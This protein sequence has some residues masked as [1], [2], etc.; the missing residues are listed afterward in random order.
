[1]DIE[2][3]EGELGEMER[4][5]RREGCGWNVLY[6]IIINKKTLSKQDGNAL[7]LALTN[8]LSP[9]PEQYF[10]MKFRGPHI[11]KKVCNLQGG[12]L[13]RKGSARQGEA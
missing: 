7:A 10:L 13:E 11:K 9:I 2:G 3:E 8:T 12:L 5:G 4:S 1:M 6:E